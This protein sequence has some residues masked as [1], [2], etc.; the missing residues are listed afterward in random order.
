MDAGA[1]TQTRRRAL[2][3]AASLALGGAALALAPRARAE[4]ATGLLWHEPGALPTQPLRELP[5]IDLD[6]RAQRIT[7]QAGRPLVL[8]F[9][10]RWCGPC[11]VEIPELVALRQREKGVDVVGL[12]LESDPA[13]VRDFARA[14]DVNYTVLLAREGGTDLMRT[15]GNAKAG[16]P[17]T[18]VLDRQ[19]SVL[20][21]RLGAINREQLD[22]AVQRALK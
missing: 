5:V 10:A 8:N 19:G 1:A 4:G 12:A 6:G 11:R 21:S 7:P 14:Y 15:L 13:A 17:F 22:A 18:V 3:Q 16:L 9:W 2:L 20:A